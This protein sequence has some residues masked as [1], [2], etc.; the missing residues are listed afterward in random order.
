MISNVKWKGRAW[1]VI[2]F[3]GVTQIEPWPFVWHWW[4]KHLTVVMNTHVNV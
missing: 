4:V 1:K 3:K 2:S